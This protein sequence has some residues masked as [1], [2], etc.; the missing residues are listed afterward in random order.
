M[1]LEQNGPVEKGM[2]W[3]AKA[4]GGSW[5]SKNEDRNIGQSGSAVQ[6]SC[7]HLSCCFSSGQFAVSVVKFKCYIGGVAH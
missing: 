6:Y 2:L 1:S 5:H 3:V 7:P 4:G